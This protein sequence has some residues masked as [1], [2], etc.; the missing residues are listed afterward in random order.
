MYMCVLYNIYSYSCTHPFT[1]VCAVCRHWTDFLSL[2]ECVRDIEG[3]GENSTMVCD[4]SFSSTSSSGSSGSH[5]EC[6]GKRNPFSKH[7]ELSASQLPRRF[8]FSLMPSAFF[9]RLLTRAASL[10]P[11]RNKVGPGWNCET[12]EADPNGWLSRGTN[13]SRVHAATVKELRQLLKMLP[14]FLHQPEINT[15]DTGSDTT[16]THTANLNFVSAMMMRS[17]CLVLQNKADAASLLLAEDQGG[18]EQRYFWAWQLMDHLCT[19]GSEIDPR[20]ISQAIEPATAGMVASALCDPEQSQMLLD[21]DGMVRYSNLQQTRRGQGRVGDGGGGGRKTKK[22]AGSS[23]G[24]NA[25]KKKTKTK[26]TTTK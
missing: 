11:N 6:T 14:N 17:S 5:R 3:H 20:V 13:A 22:R 25:R 18:S 8:D 19:Q 7:P 12:I 9:A 26:T 15:A 2:A 16:E 10:T 24:S 4:S 1:E 21:P 23:A